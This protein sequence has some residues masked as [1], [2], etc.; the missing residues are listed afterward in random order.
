MSSQNKFAKA[1]SGI[2]VRPLLLKVDLRNARTN[3]ECRH[4]EASCH[5]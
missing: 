5:T 3:F 4:A 1:A 2:R